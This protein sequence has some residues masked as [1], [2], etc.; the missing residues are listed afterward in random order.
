MRLCLRGTHFFYLVMLTCGLGRPSQAADMVLPAP[1][2]SPLRVERLPLASGAKL[3]TF[4]ER[5]PEEATIARPELPL[6][7]ILKDT[8]NDSDPVTTAS[9]RSGS[10]LIRNRRSGRGWRAGFRFFIIALGSTAVPETDLRAPV[11][12][13]A[14]HRVACGRPGLSGVQSEVLNPWAIARLTTHSFFGNY[15]EYRK[16]H[17]WEAADVLRRF[18]RISTSSTTGLTAEKSGR[19]GKTR[20]LRTIRSAAWSAMNFLERDQRNNGPS[21]PRPGAI[22]GNCCASA[23][24]RPV[25]IYSLLTAGLPASFAILWVAETDLENAA[26]RS[27]DRQFLNISNPFSDERLRHWE[28][29]SEMWNLDRRAFWSRRI[30]RT[31][32]R[33]G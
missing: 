33:S 4:F 7:A 24:K 20:T 22:T 12:D 16:T 11:L 31:R 23:R 32:S 18:A 28:G 3:I 29:Y 25:C 30:P 9:G 21:K 1:P 26:G 6:I 10:S 5:L 8:L 2:P 17:I 19:R 14:I 13:L 15:G 27:F